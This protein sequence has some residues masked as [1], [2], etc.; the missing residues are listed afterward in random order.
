MHNPHNDF[1]HYLSG[2]TVALIGRAPYIMEMEQGDLIDSHDIVVRMHYPTP[3]ENFSDTKNMEVQGIIPTYA[4]KY[5]GERTNVLYDNL[6][7]P[8]GN[9][10]V[11]GIQ[12]MKSTDGE[13]V[14]IGNIL[15]LANTTTMLWTL[16]MYDSIADIMGSKIRIV[17]LIAYMDLARKLSHKLPV[18]GTIALYDLLLHG[19]S[20]LYIT[21]MTNWQGKGENALDIEQHG[22]EVLP[23]FNFVRGLIEFDKRISIDPYMQKVYFGD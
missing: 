23:N 16:G 9:D 8:W 4:V 18:A 1:A 13:W 7:H 12:K 10:H 19:V 3:N 14:C 15:S 11:A 17:D 2:K 20:S 22:Y 21:G 5:I 6:Q